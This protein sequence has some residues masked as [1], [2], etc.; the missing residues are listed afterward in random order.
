MLKVSSVKTYNTVQNSS[1]AIYVKKG[2][3]TRII[4]YIP[5]YYLKNLYITSIKKWLN[6]KTRTGT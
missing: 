2:K 5:I 6:F 1:L 4:L 3:S